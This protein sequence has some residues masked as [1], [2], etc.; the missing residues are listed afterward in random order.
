[1]AETDETEEMSVADA[2]AE[3]EATLGYVFKD[4][5]LLETAMTAP[6]FRAACGAAPCAD[7]QRLEFLGDAVLGLL[8]AE[9]LFNTHQDVGEGVLTIR[10]SHLA[11]G[12]A[13]ARRARRVGLGAYL[14]IGL[15]DKMTGG[16]NKDRLLAEAMEA[17]FGALWCDGGLPA[18]RP[19]FEAMLKLEEEVPAAE[20]QDDNPKG[21]LQEIAQ[22]CA[23]AGLPLYEIVSATGPDHAPSYV[24]RVRVEGE[25]EALGDGTTKRAAMVA[26]ARRMLEMLK[27][28][29]IA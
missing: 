6:S 7:N 8:A 22:R 27:A 16:V 10:R 21:H 11:S 15:G 28:E 2:L 19:V 25:R 17:L 24:V 14:R 9:H 23:W 20:L 12:T 13:L 26:A 1:M 4:R 18:A 29:G 5:A 3:L